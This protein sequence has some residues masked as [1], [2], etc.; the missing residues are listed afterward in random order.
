MRLSTI[1]I[2]HPLQ[3]RDMTS[4]LSTDLVERRSFSYFS[5]TID[6]TMGNEVD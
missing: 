4:V 1:K 5:Y 2:F 6:E 3:K